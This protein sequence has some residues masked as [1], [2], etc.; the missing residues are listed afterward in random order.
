MRLDI[1]PDEAYYWDWHR[2]L[3]FGYFDHPPMIAWLVHVTTLLL[4]DTYWGIKAVPLLLGIGFSIVMLL[5]AGL[6]K[7]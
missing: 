4:G 5:L 6:G 2:F 7:N 3:S 1:F